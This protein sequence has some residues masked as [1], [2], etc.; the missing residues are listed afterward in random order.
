MAAGHAEGIWVTFAFGGFSS[1]RPSG[2]RRTPDRGMRTVHPFVYNSAR[3]PALLVAPFPLFAEC[4]MKKILVALLSV[5]A[6][7]EAVLVAATNL[8]AAVPSIPIP[9]P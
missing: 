8:A 7:S 6:L 4:V 2:S 1:L 9:P 3:N 5:F